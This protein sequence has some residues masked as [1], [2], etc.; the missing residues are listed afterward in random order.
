VR[1]ATPA[2]AEAPYT[3]EA[4]DRLRV[5]V[6]GRQIPTHSYQVDAA[7]TVTLPRIGGVPVRGLTP[8]QLSQV[9]ATRLQQDHMGEPQVA[10]EM[11]AYRPFFVV[12][13]V[14]QPGQFPYVPDMTVETAVA[15]AGGFAPRADDTVIHLGR[16][17]DGT[18]VRSKVSP[19][20]RIRAGDTV[21][22][23]AR[24]F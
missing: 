15:I 11:E 17:I 19:D 5:V 10:V 18:L 14:M 3:L 4:G 2:A 8:A 9:I 6:A 1:T 12:G 22:V 21:T 7:G 24:R 13:E 16:V 20:T 23:D